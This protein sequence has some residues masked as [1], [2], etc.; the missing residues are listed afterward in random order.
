MSIIFGTFFPFLNFTKLFGRPSSSKK[1]TSVQNF[2]VCFLSVLKIRVR[3][4][5]EDKDHNSPLENESQWLEKSE[6]R[7]RDTIE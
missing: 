3:V 4:L 1:Q 5:V 2:D 7:H 6:K